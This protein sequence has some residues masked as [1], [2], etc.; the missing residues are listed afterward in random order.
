MQILNSLVPIFVIIALGAVLRRRGFLTA[1]ITQGFNRFAYF[2]ALPIYL[3]YKLGSAADVGGT[4]NWFV[5]VL[6]AATLIAAAVGWLLSIAM[7]M[8]RTSRGTLIQAC[9]RGNLAFI[10]LPL[11]LFATYDLPVV[12]REALESAV[13]VAFSP[14]VI[15]YNILAVFV[16]AIYNTRSESKVSWKATFQAIITNP[17]LLACLAGLLVQKNGWTI[18]VSVYRSCEAIGAA[19]FPMA[20]IGIGSQ[21]VSISGSD[22][23]LQAG[24]AALVKCVVCPLSAWAITMGLGFTAAE[25]LAILV[26]CAAPTAVSSFVLADQM[27]GDSDLA[28]S[29]VVLCTAFS[30]VTLSTLLTVAPL[31]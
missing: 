4:A 6:V 2:F 27:G 21:L 3:F 30:F 14:V 1:E 16:L 15:L 13:L 22:Q 9:F 23:W 28:A 12:E 31:M 19:A 26:L 5:V 20:L 24:L 25:Q 18:P 7:K 8:P 11:I 10:G 17:I 29:S